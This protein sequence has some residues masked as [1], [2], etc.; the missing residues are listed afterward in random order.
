MHSFS[1]I[2]LPRVFSRAANFTFNSHGTDLQEKV[3]S[4][5]QEGRS[6]LLLHFPE[7]NGITFTTCLL[8]VWPNEQSNYLVDEDKEVHSLELP[9]PKPHYYRI[10]RRSD[11]CLQNVS[12]IETL[13]K[14]TL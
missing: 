2:N 13:H 4:Q 14:P 10:T 7:E 1:S 8:N 12:P 6:F 3:P 11:E 5:H 9:K